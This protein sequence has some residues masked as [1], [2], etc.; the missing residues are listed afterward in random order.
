MDFSKIYAL[1][2]YAKRY[3]HNQI[4]KVGVS[5]TEHLI[6]AF[7]FGHSRS[8]QDDIAEALKLD[9]TTVARALLSLEGKGF[10]ERTPNPENRRKN[11]ISITEAGKENVSDVVNVYDSWMDQVSQAL[12]VEECRQFEEY[13]QRLLEKAENISKGMD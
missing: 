10:V 7:V 5:D 12:T 6:C 11:I 2:Q 1:M 9:K 3:S 4:K 8:S 13:C